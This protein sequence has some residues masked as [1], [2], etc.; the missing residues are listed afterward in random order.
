MLE[1]LWPVIEAWP[2]SRTIRSSI[3]LYPALS[4]LHIA[5]LGSLFGALLVHHLALWR[6]EAQ[7]VALPVI[8]WALVVAVTSGIF[9]FLPRAGHY[10]ANPAFQIKL[11]FIGA[12][13]LNAALFHLWRQ[14]PQRGLAA[15]SLGLWAGAL[16]SGRWIAYSGL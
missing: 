3:R 8:R 16:F 11:F 7:T 14:A 4:A 10:A 9:L 12:A 13:C 5:G 15:L 2:V 6:R 1:S